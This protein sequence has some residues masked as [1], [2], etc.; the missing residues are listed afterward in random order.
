MDACVSNLTY[1]RGQ[2][3]WALWRSFR[4]LGS[5]DEGP[6]PIFKTR[7]KRLLDLDRELDVTQL[8][9]RPPSDFAFVTSFEGGSG[10][11]AAYA[12]ADVFA[13]ALALDLLDVGFKQGEIVYV[14]RHLR[15]VLDDWYPDLIKRP[16][17]ND[18]QK[19]LAAHFP[20]LPRY[21]PGPGKA[22]LADARVFLILNRIEITEVLAVAGAKPGHAV[23][24]QPEVC[25][26]LA[27]L[28]ARLHDVMP[29]RRRTVILLEITAIAQAVTHYLHEAPV[30]ARGRPRRE[31]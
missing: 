16:S 7:I 22:A 12:P 11:E 27:A 13:L 5:R 20:K 23:F 31:R 14:M 1:K 30:V 24:L 9:S 6:P 15:E 21:E 4:P 2:I 10:V 17:L 18:R 3:E 26:G 19:R 29:L 25:E 28:E 8:A